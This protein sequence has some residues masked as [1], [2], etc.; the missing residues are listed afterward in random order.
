M[1]LKDDQWEELYVFAKD[2]ADYKI[3]FEENEKC[4][5][6]ERYWRGMV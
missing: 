2:L 3:S 5:M 4:S 1:I 6:E